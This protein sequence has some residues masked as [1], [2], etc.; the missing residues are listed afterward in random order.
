[1]IDRNVPERRSEWFGTGTATVVSSGLRCDCPFA[2]LR[3][4]HFL[5]ECDKR[6]VLIRCGAYPTATSRRVMK[7]SVRK[8]LFTSEGSATSKNSSTASV[9]FCLAASMVSP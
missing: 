1:M 2:G 5:V 7:T 3:R 8:R 9:R 4:N 6:A